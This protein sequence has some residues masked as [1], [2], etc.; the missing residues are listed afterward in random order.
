MDFNDSQPA[1]VCSP[2]QLI[3]VATEM[4]L[5]TSETNIEEMELLTAFR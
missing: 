2:W 3:G 1:L 4:K 5:L